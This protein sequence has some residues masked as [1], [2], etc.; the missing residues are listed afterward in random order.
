MQTR[1]MERASE[2]GAWPCDYAGAAAARFKL[3]AAQ[4]APT[5]KPADPARPGTRIAQADLKH[6]QVQDL[7]DVM[8]DLLKAKANYA[9][10]FHVRIE[11]GGRQ[12][13]PDAT[14]DAINRVLAKVSKDMRVE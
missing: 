7:A 6:S 12:P 11:V 10:R 14:I 8:G 3:A 13:P 4:P 9:L 1:Y 5:P 2:S